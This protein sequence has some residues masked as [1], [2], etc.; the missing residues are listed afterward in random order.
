MGL[1]S[2]IG[3]NRASG[4][5]RK[6]WDPV[7][8]TRHADTAPVATSLGVPG[9]KMPAPWRPLAST[10]A[11]PLSVLGSCVTRTAVTAVGLASVSTISVAPGWLF[12]ASPGDVHP[13]SMSPS[14]KFAMPAA[15]CVSSKPLACRQTMEDTCT[16]CTL[17]PQLNSSISITFHW[18]VIASSAICAGALLVMRTSDT[19]AAPWDRPHSNP[20][21]NRISCLA[22]KLPFAS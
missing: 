1:E 4:V 10:E 21:E 17:N 12:I 3:V 16:R 9:A 22:F 2:S 7:A 5:V 19:R 6:S 11:T 8:G 13:V 14:T 18:S 20:W 15:Q